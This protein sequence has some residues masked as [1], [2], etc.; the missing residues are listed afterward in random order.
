MRFNSE[1]MQH[2]HKYCSPSTGIELRSPN[3][4]AAPGVTM[5]LR[6][7]DARL[8]PEPPPEPVL[9]NQQ[10]SDKFIVGAAQLLHLLPVSTV[11]LTGTTLL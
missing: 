3:A 1:H 10:R 5:P 6:S 2:T 8:P 7:P 4:E 11:S 9:Q